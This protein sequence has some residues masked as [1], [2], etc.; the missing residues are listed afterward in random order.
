MTA[1]DA[2]M[3]R[4]KHGASTFE[5]RE[6]ANYD[7]F[8][9]LH[10]RFEECPK[11]D[12][13][14][15]RWRARCVDTW[16]KLD[17]LLSGTFTGGRCAGHLVSGFGTLPMSPNVVYGHSLRMIKTLEAAAT[18]YSQFVYSLSWVEKVPKAEYWAGSY[19]HGQRFVT[20]LQQRPLDAIAGQLE[21][22]AL[23]CAPFPAQTY[24]SSPDVFLTD[25]SPGDEALILPEHSAIYLHLSAS[26]PMLGTYHSV[27]KATV[28]CMHTAKPL[29]LALLQKSL[30]ELTAI[31]IFAMPR[32]FP[33]ER[34]HILQLHRRIRNIREL[35]GARPE[36][37][38]PAGVSPDLTLPDDGVL[39]YFWAL[40]PKASIPALR[41]SF[42][43]AFAYLLGK[44]PEDQLR[45]FHY[46][47]G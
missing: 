20:M 21:Y 9:T 28:R 23:R 43:H 19:H 26:H 8:L 14:R 46:S 10:E 24:P 31:N 12:D 32:L 1:L 18:A 4:L 7:A 30:P 44:Y 15:T 2:L 29:A 39:M 36:L 33:V 11:A 27:S 34:N 13:A 3:E 42:H 17:S 40:T 25:S 37:I 22:Y 38:L 35:E 6:P 41:Q 16:S 45:A 5:I 47:L